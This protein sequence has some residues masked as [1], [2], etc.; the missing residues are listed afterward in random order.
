MSVLNLT[1][2]IADWVR[3]AVTEKE[4]MTDLTKMGTMQQMQL[5]VFDSRCD[6]TQ[7]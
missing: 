4:V 7:A 5:Q 3:L 2:T 6:T 1:M